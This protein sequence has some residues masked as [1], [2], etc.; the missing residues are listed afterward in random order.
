L[1]GYFSFAVTKSV[2][3]FFIYPHYQIFTYP[4]PL[5]H[6]TLFFSCFY[7]FCFHLLWT[8]CAFSPATGPSFFLLFFPVLSY[9]SVR[10]SPGRIRSLLPL[11]PTNGMSG[12]PPPPRRLTPLLYRFVCHRVGCETG[13]T[14]CDR[15]WIRSCFRPVCAGVFSR[16]FSLVFSSFFFVPWR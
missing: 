2:P 12:S 14:V 10:R 3:A 8:S 7:L 6:G 4:A 16:A 13:S 1:S 9:R 15:L 11:L 5:L